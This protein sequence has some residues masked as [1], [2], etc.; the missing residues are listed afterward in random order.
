MDPWQTVLNA[1]RHQRFGTGQCLGVDSKPK[2]AQRLTASEVWHGLAVVMLIGSTASAQRLTAS[3]VWHLLN[4]FNAGVGRVLNALR[5]QRFG[6]N[7]RS[8]ASNAS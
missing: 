8:S 3:E 1:L 2:G 4:D 5:H 6:T 7:L